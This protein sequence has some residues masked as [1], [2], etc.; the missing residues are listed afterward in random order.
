MILNNSALHDPCLE[1]LCD[2]LDLKPRH[3]WLEALRIGV[4]PKAS[5]RITLTDP[6]VWEQTLV[7]FTDRTATEAFT[8]HAASQLLLDVWLWIA[9]CYATPEESMFARLAELTRASGHPALNIAHCLRDMAFGD[10]SRADDLGQM[11]RS[12]DPNYRKLFADALWVDP[13]EDL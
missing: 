5:Q 9:E 2:L 12:K 1:L 11:L 4:L 10:T 6:A 8:F 3:H 13:T 7:A